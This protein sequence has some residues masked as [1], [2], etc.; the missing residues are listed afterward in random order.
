M[1]LET[2]YVAKSIFKELSGY[3][4]WT[5]V[6]TFLACGLQGVI[7]KQKINLRDIKLKKDGLL[8]KAL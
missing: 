6:S 7:I 1:N 3:E 2:K 8:V 5:E 4:K